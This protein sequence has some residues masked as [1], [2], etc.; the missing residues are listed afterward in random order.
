MKVLCLGEPVLR[1]SPRPPLMLHQTDQLSM[2]F[3]GSEV[4]VAKSLALQGDDVALASVVSSNTLGERSLMELRRF[5]VDVSRVQRAD[6]R[7]GVYYVE[8]GG[9]V[10]PDRVLYDRDGTAMRDV[11]RDDFDWDGLLNGVGS[12]YFSGVVAS[13]TSTL[14]DVVEDA[15]VASKGRGIRTFCDLNFR[16]GMITPAAAR[17]LWGRLLPYVDVVCGSDEDY[18]GIWEREGFE[19]D[20]D[21]CAAAADRLMT[22]N[23]IQSLA[24]NRRD[25]DAG[26]LL[27]VRGMLLSEKGLFRSRSRDVA[28]M[29]QSG[30]GDAFSAS[31]VHGLLNRWDAQHTLDYAVAH[32]AYKATVEG[33]LSWADESTIERI[34]TGDARGS[35]IR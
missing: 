14:G 25:V 32:A 24:M 6:C 1:L 30:C 22:A 35:I 15:L 33:E 13:I 2:A 28:P 19:G 11:G 20:G 12:F 7:L 34:V 10:R 29:E 26:G 27:S 31:I 16:R 5:G 3:A 17:E 23:G 21:Q 18:V 8:R 4:T 9:T